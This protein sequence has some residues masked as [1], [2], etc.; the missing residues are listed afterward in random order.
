MHWQAG[1]LLPCLLAAQPDVLTYHN[2]V[3]RT[4]Q[5]LAETILGEFN[6]VTTVREARLSSTDTHVTIDGNIKTRLAL[7]MNTAER[8]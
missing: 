2:D 3:A 4:G 8:R 1:L 5:N 6:K 7:P